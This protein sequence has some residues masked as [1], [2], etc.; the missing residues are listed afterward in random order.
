M[1][2]LVILGLYIIAGCIVSSYLHRKKMMVA[3]VAYQIF[4]WVNILYIPY[5]LNYKLF[6]PYLKELFPNISQIL[7]YNIINQPILLSADKF[8][9][10]CIT[11]IVFSL[12]LILA[13]TL[14]TVEILSTVISSGKKN[15]NKQLRPQINFPTTA[16]QLGATFSRVPF[17]LRYCSLIS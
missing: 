11:A 5:I 7:L 14:V 1:K 3:F 13:L 17:W 6:L 16:D 15:K 8:N 4:F 9:L 10:L 2:T 12:L